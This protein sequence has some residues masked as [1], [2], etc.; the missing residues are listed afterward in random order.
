MH[1]HRSSIRLRLYGSRL[2]SASSTRSA[3]DVLGL[4]PGATEKE[5]Q[6]AYRSLA[7]RWHP[8]RPEGCSTRFREILQARETLADRTK[9]H[10]GETPRWSYQK[11]YEDQDDSYDFHQH[12][13]Q[14]HRARPEHDE[15][16]S[17]TSEEE[18][19]EKHEESRRKRGHRNDPRDEEDDNRLV[20]WGLQFLV[21]FL[22]FRVAVI[23]VFKHVPTRAELLERERLRAIK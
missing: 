12:H 10:G 7:K 20:R 6:E 18:L 17:F 2:L 23:F 3:H 9:M 15:E 5:V 19:R 8:D 22:A 21:G 1:L 13:R 4:T 14:R 11:G 16:W